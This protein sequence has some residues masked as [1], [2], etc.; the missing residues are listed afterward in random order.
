VDKVYVVCSN[1]GI[2]LSCDFENSGLPSFRAVCD[3]LREKSF[4]FAIVI[5]AI[6]IPIVWWKFR[7]PVDSSKSVE[8]V[9]AKCDYDCM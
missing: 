7:I 3:C 5:G 4:N 2:Q 8:F 1:I 6:S 9:S